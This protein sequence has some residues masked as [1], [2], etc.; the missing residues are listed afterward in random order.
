MG[1]YA[2]SEEEKEDFI[3]D[4][5]IG[6][7]RSGNTI[8]FDEYLK[9]SL[10]PIEIDT[11]YMILGHL[12]YHLQTSSF[13]SLAVCR[14]KQL[15]PLIKKYRF[16]EHS[17]Y[18]RLSKSDEEHQELKKKHLQ[19]QIDLLHIRQKEIQLMD[20][21]KELNSQIDLTNKLTV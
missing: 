21:I 7:R 17:E 18:E 3:K 10:S 4:K 11:L 12:S 6:K 16:I 2:F 9:I 14:E 19:L 15:I 1:I 13:Q 20:E 5:I 8:K